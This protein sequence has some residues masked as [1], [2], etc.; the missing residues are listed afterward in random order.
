MRDKQVAQFPPTDG[1]AGELCTAIIDMIALYER[2]I[3]YASAIGAIEIAKQTVM[4]RQN[5]AMRG[6]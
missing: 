6:E 1:A 5:A 2:R 4:D 3:S